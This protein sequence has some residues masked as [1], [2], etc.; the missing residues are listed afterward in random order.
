MIQT[1]L[2]LL[3]FISIVCLCFSC[4]RRGNPTGGPLDSIPPVLVKSDPEFE[5]INFTK[6]KFKIYFD[7]YVK[8]KDAKNNLVISPPQKYEPIITPLGSA[9]KFISIKILDTLDANTTYS[10]NF[11]NSI[12]DNNE[13]NELGN[14]KY[15]FS[16][17]SYIDSLNLAGEVLDPLINDVTKNIDVMLYEYNEYFTDSTIF[18]EKPRYIA[19]SLDSSL[20]EITNLRAGKYLLIGVDDRNNN[21]IY[22]PLSDKIGYLADTISIPTDSSFN[23]IIFKEIPELKVVKPKEIDKGHLIFGFMGNADDLI[24]ELLTEKPGD[25]KS[26]I[27]YEKDMDTLNYWYTPFEND[28]LNFRVSL[29]D[30]SEDFIL[31]TRKPDIDSLNVSMYSGGVLHLLDTFSIST[32]TPIVNFDKSLI[33]VTDIDT[34]EV[35]FNTIINKSKTQLYIDFE[36]NTKILIKLNFYPIQLRIFLEFQTIP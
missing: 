5:S 20:Y 8:L 32:N 1:L 10:F 34:I 25:F 35:N 31:K 36:K 9:S 2:K 16:T 17:G 7:E 3:F 6:K 21:N 33:K 29:G 11:G 28:S 22:D 24:V 30:Y 26:F 14:F 18:K 23:L 27:V 12:V 13:E 4:A 15:V 19:N